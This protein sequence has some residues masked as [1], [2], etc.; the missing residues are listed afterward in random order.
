[1]LLFWSFWQI[2]RD[3]AGITGPE[4]GGFAD[5]LRW[6]IQFENGFDDRDSSYHPSRVRPRRRL[7]LQ[8][9]R[10]CTRILM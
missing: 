3:G 2:Q 9:R 4:F 1:M 7:G 8:V 10:F 5:H 6:K